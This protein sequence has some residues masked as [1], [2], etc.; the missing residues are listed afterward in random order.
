M[1]R[2]PQGID[3][4]RTKNDRSSPC[5]Q[6]MP[7]LFMPMLKDDKSK[8]YVPS[9]TLTTTGGN[10]SPAIHCLSPP[11]NRGELDIDINHFPTTL[12]EEATECVSRVR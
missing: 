9:T 10:I 4:H 5:F 1:V 3:Q 12:A 11:V 8:K 2:T 6:T 7:E